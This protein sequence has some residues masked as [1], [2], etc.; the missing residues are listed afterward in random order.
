MSIDWGQMV[1]PEAGHG[2]SRL[3]RGGRLRSRGVLSWF[4]RAASALVLGVLVVLAACSGGDSASDDAGEESEQDDSPSEVVTSTTLD[5][6]A[7]AV[8]EGYEAYWTAFLAAADPP[9]PESEQL[10]EHAAGDELEQVRSA[11]GALASGG[12]VLRGAYEHNAAV[13]SIEEDAAVVTDCLAPRTTTVD[14]ATGDVIV[15]ESNG[16]GLVTAQMVLD[17]DVWKVA[18]VEDGDGACPP[19]GVAPVAPP[20]ADG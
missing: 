2:A 4:G 12:D 9:T 15:G 11:L 14:A 19:P 3:V 20:P 5:P 17:G 1:C 13:T 6:R 8:I 16:S 7:P 10:A 18:L